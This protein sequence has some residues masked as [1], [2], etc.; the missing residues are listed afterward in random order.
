MNRFDVIAFYKF[1]DLPHFAELRTPLLSLC[2]DHDIRGTILLARE[3]INGTIAGVPENLAA[4]RA[5][6]RAFPAFHDLEAKR[7]FTHTM[8]FRRMKVRLKKEIVT[9][10]VSGV[11]TKL[12][13]GQYVAPRDWNALLADPEVLV[14]DTRNGFEVAAGSFEGAIDPQTRRFGDFPDFVRTRLAAEKHRKIAM[15]CTGGIRCEKA[16]SFMLGQGL[17]QVYQ[18]QGGILKYLE[19]IPADESLWRGAC[20]VFDER[21]GLTQGFA[22]TRDCPPVSPPTTENGRSRGRSSSS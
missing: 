15:F 5:G 13:T 2:R 10:G 17:S 4:A 22:K 8:P 20:F 18:L 9:L 3:G 14:I 21:V 7:S 11:D 12:R 19:D 6:I 16:S 1:V